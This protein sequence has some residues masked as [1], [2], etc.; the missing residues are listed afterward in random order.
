MRGGGRVGGHRA[1][2][3]TRLLISHNSTLYCAEC[4]INGRRSSPGRSRK[5]YRWRIPGRG[6]VNEPKEF[7]EHRARAIAAD[8]SLG[9]EFGST[10]KA[11]LIG[12]RCSAR[13]RRPRLEP[14]GGRPVVPTLDG[15]WESG[16]RSLLCLPG[17][18]RSRALRCHPTFYGSIGISGMML[19]RLR[20]R[21]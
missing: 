9:I 3:V 4:S 5:C 6:L 20:C 17:R 10:R 1:D 15:S 12:P 16:L 13:H 2:G 21:R 14:P 18:R 19:P 8:T 11:V 7:Y